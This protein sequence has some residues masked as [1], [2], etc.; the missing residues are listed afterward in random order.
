VGNPYPTN[1]LLTNYE[2]ITMRKRLSV[3]QRTL[4]ISGIALLQ[5]VTHA[6]TEVITI[7]SKTVCDKPFKLPMKSTAELPLTFKLE[8][9]SGGC[10]VDSV[11]LVTI[12]GQGT[13]IIKASNP[14]NATYN[15]VERQARFN[16]LPTC[17]TAEEK[18]KV[19]VVR[20]VAYY[21][22]AGSAFA[23]KGVLSG[24]LKYAVEQFGKDG[25]QNLAFP[26][27]VRYQAGRE[28]PRNTLVTFTLSGGKVIWGTT[29][30]GADLTVPKADGTKINVTLTGKGG[31]SDNSVTYSLNEPL[32][33]DDALNFSFK[34]G[35]VQQTLQ[36]PGRNVA[37][38]TTVKDASG[39]QIAP[40]LSTVLATAVETLGVDF[41]LNAA[42]NKPAFIDGNADLK[43]FVGSGNIS[44][45][46]VSYGQ[47]RLT[48]TAKG[49]AAATTC[50]STAN[51]S[52]CQST[53][54]SAK[55]NLSTGSLS[56]E[57]GNFSA[58]GKPED[59]K[60][61]LDTTRKILPTNLVNSTEANWALEASDL[62][63]LFTAKGDIILTVDGETEINRNRTPPQGTFTATFSSG[64]T[65][66]RFATLRHLKVNGTVCTLYNIPP[67]NALDIVAIRVTNQSDS[68]DGWVKGTLRDVDNK[69]IFSGK[70]L[71]EQNN[72][73]PHQ[74]VRLQMEDLTADGAS[75]TGR[76]VL[77]LHSNVPYPELQ[78][79][80]FLRAREATGFPETPMMNMS[81][82][83]S[84]QP[85]E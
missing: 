74:T 33:A 76:A 60:V 73:M 12:T 17:A 81:R 61:Y 77:M 84:G 10:Q 23:E 2:E 47:L 13:C 1:F 16:I 46:Q 79:F 30:S 26:F 36:F 48:E 49:L 65:I 24:P 75:W 9:G 19:P 58:S 42:D 78:I 7:N 11:G 4:V 35:N 45:T 62:Q 41:G 39:K 53:L 63:D 70:V 54:W 67:S 66:S 51:N 56:I 27:Q 72:L 43:M 38:T 71:I 14:G 57:K 6:E 83:A 50:P 82:G 85:C 52:T 69:V 18:E 55:E 15:P 31:T 25:P 32:V 29:L 3:L 22:P 80:G 37:I 44:D 21:A 28:L 34:L 64:Q 20:L 68:A 5:G 40:T 8:A 59:G